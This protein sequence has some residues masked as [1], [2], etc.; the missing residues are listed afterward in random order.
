M[1]RNYVDDGALNA[2]YIEYET[3]QVFFRETTLE[4]FAKA[5]RTRRNGPRGHRRRPFNRKIRKD[6]VKNLKDAAAA[7]G[8]SETYKLEKI[9]EA[10]F[11]PGVPPPD[12]D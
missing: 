3:S 11:G 12:S 4:R 1:V 9:L 7:D 10:V 6:L 8:I 2:D 5:K